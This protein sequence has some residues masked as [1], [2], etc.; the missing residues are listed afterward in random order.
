VVDDDGRDRV[1]AGAAVLRRH[2]DAEHTQISELAE[3][4]DVQ[5]PLAVVRGGLRVDLLLRE[6]RDRLAQEAVL[7]GRIEQGVGVT[8]GPA[9]SRAVRSRA[10]SPV[11]KLS[12][13]A[14]G[15]RADRGPCGAASGLY[16]SRR[17][18]DA[19][20]MSRWLRALFFVALACAVSARA[21]A[22]D[23]VVVALGGNATEVERA[24]VLNAVAARFAADGFVVLGPTELVHRVPPS[25]LALSTTEDAARLAA[26]VHV[27]RVACVSVWASSG[28]VTELSLSLHALSGDRSV[29]HSSASG[30]L[31]PERDMVS[32][33]D[34]MVA[35]VLASERAAAML[36]P[37]MGSGS[38]SSTASSG[39]APSGGGASSSSASVS[40]SSA[41]SVAAA[42]TEDGQSG[43][44]E[45]LFGILGPGLL[46]AIG[47]AATGLGIWASLDTVCE[48]FNADR[49]I[50]LR[51][52]EQNLAAG[53]PMIIGGAA[54]LAGAI[55]WWITDAEAPE[56]EPRIDVVI[57]PGSAGVRGTF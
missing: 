1:H 51:G 44:P 46:A 55:V 25:R 15:P 40:S 45:L 7:F 6:L 33:I 54:A 2:G 16:A 10:G 12:L 35:Q 20:A 19:A 39:G 53:I 28:A 29:R 50:C 11:R 34:G 4:R 27:P 18:C 36:D 41:P 31:S 26:E 43:G 47:A 32:T 52:E 5:R 24:P 37:G 30:T 22:Q 21:A 14:R 13:S 9:P 49:S 57:G 23:V 8:H 48:R 17:S 42:T 38:G 3:E 56:T